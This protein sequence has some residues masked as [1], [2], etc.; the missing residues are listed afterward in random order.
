VYL[1]VFHAY[2][3]W[4]FLIF[5][6]LT[7]RRLYKSFG[8]KELMYISLHAVSV[9]ARKKKRSMSYMFRFF[10]WLS[11]WKIIADMSYISI[12]LHILP[13]NKFHNKTRQCNCE[14]NTEARFCNHCC[15]EKTINIAHSE[16]V[17]VC[18]CVCV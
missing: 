13:L 18:V 6:E 15:S 14:R 10:G 16:C 2:F 1:L 3:Y 7:A 4:G 17:C 8:V 11:R 9:D 5:K 12:E